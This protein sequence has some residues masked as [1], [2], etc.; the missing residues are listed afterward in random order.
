MKPDQ[1]N[2]NRE[3]QRSSPEG[4]LFLDFPLL[5]RRWDSQKHW[6]KDPW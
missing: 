5:I 1:K 3:K 6:V 4:R 2:S